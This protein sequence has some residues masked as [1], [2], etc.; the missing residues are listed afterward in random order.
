MGVSGEIVNAGQDTTRDITALSVGSVL[1]Y[2]QEARDEH[3]ELQGQIPA[4]RKMKAEQRGD[5][6]EGS[7]FMGVRFVVA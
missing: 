6:T 5:F 7:I 1:T 3:L 2:A 4:E